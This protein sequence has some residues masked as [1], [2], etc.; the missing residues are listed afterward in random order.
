MKQR[1]TL[2][3]FIA[4]VWTKTLLGLAITPYKSVRELTRHR[5]LLPVVFSPLYGL[6]ILF[7]VGRVGSYVF[8]VDGIIRS[9]LA[10]I[11]SS[12]LLSILM[13]QALLIYLLLSFY[14]ALRKI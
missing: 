12:A 5:V 10:F 1:P 3:L 4:Y 2:L 7:V 8:E 11:L 9:S 6:A 14:L 13:W